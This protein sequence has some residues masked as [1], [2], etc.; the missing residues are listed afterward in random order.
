MPNSGFNSP[1]EINTA[2]KKN[3]LD[4]LIENVVFFTWTRVRT[5]RYIM[6]SIKKLHLTQKEITWTNF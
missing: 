4:N 3:Y 1:L 5:E 6:L 2:N